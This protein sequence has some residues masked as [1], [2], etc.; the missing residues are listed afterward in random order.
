MR[1]LVGSN[2]WAVLLVPLLPHDCLAVVASNTP[3]AIG[4]GDTVG[5]GARGLL[6]GRGCIACW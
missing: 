1:G 6:A 2:D 3:Y 4:A 5:A